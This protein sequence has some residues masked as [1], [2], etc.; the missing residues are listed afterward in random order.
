MVL[1]LL[2]ILR[3]EVQLTTLAAGHLVGLVLQLVLGVQASLDTAS[4]VNFLLRVQQGNLTD[5]LE[6]VLHRVGG[7]TGDSHL[8]NR[9]VG[10]VGIRDHETTL[11]MNAGVG[12][13]TQRSTLSDLRILFLGL[14]LGVGHFLIVGVCLEIGILKIFA[15]G[16]EVFLDGVIEFL[17]GNLF[18]DFLVLLLATARLLGRR[19][20][21]GLLH[22]GVG[23]LCGLLGRSLLRRGLIS[24]GGVGLL[25]RLL[26]GSLLRRR[27]LRGRLLFLGWCTSR[28][29][30]GLLGARRLLRGGRH[31]RG[32]LSRRGVLCR[33][34]RCTHTGPFH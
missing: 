2:T 6:V 30:R 26:R 10:L 3:E 24:L 28:G 16:L 14:F 32:F 13:F 29:G 12:A 15:R 9:L 33:S 27:L 8:L 25:R 17:D 5:L 1:C 19:L 4:K 20:L 7:R 18:D 21:R 23:F 22:V 34:A 11:D 31:L